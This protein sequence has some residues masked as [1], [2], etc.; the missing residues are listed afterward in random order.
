MPGPSFAP[1][2]VG[3]GA[4]VLQQDVSTPTVPQGLRIPAPIGQGTKTLLRYDNIIKGA[5]NGQDGP[6]TNNIV[7]DV[8]SVIDVNNVVYVKNRDFI[9]TRIGDTAVIDWSPKAALTGSVDLTTLTYPTQLDGKTLRLR[10]D[11]VDYAV[12]FTAPANAAAVVTQINSWDPALAGLA[13]L[14]SGSLLV[15]TANE[16]IIET[17]NTVGILGFVVGDSAAV[18][19]PAVGVAYRVFYL[20]DKVTAE[21]APKLFSNM[22]SVIAWCGSLNAPT[23]LTSGTAS[24]AA[25]R[26]LTV[27]G[28]PWVANAYIGRY[29]KITGG[30]GK[31]QVRVVISNTTSVLTVSQA[32]S[33]YNTPDSTSTFQ[34]TDVNDNSISRGAQTMVDAG[35]SFLITSQYQDDLFD[36]NNIKFAIDAL[37]QDVS[38]YRPECLVLMRGIGSTETSIITYL[39]AHVDEQSNELNNHFRVA[40]IGMASGVEDFLT[41][42]SLATG[43][44]DR[45]VTIVNISTMPKDFGFGIEYLDGS[46]VAAGYAGVYCDK[47]VD[48]GEPITLKSLGAVYDVDHFVDPFLVSEKDQ[49]ASAGIT[50]IERDGLDLVIRHALTTDNSTTFTWEAKLTRSAD[51]VSNSVRKVLRETVIGK[52]FTVS[53]TGS[54]D[55]LLL[56][57]ANVSFVLQGMKNPLKQIIVGFGTD[58]NGSDSNIGVGQNASV[59]QELDLNTNVSL[60]TDVVWA[61]AVLGFKAG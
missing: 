30:T 25:A 2:Y 49:M 41:F 37:K 46:Y 33:T 36:S 16:V 15:L 47:S 31:G 43:T 22:N 8:Q 38:G 27:A 34:I 59:P 3:P 19:E 28:T 42:V 10:V 21:Y 52:R 18:Q 35:A 58:P 13:S 40:I 48:A 6:L 11:G 23:I 24:T 39:K 61:L 45:R 17:S 60:T 57:K 56:A 26:T 12:V 4:Y 29:V 53:P 1:G 32:W 7:I 55:A 9:L 14:T 20:S 51:F 50:V 5:K 44:K 54:Q